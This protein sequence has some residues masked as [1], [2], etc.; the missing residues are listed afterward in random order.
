MDRKEKT[1][2]SDV[3]ERSREAFDTSKAFASDKKDE[4]VSKADDAVHQLNDRMEKLRIDAFAKAQNL[5]EKGRKQW[6]SIQHT[7]DEKYREA[8]QDLHDIKEN[9]GDAWKT[10]RDGFTSAYEEMKG[11][12]Q[13]ATKTFKD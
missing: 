7:Y 4:F 13:Q 12:Y 5:S 1:T 8:M 3:K 11:A 9:G 10:V 6:Q 2:M